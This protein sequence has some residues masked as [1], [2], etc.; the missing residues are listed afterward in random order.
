MNDRLHTSSG[1]PFQPD[2]DGLWTMSFSRAERRAL[3]AAFKADVEL[4]GE[5]ECYL[6]ALDDHLARTF[7]LAFAR[8]L[9]AEPD[10]RPVGAMPVALSATIAAALGAGDTLDPRCT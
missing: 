3:V 5:I 8:H 4:R 9:V 7:A 10:A 1:R 6:R 2:P